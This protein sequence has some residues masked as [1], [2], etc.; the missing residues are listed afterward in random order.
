MSTI[1]AP[2]GKG[3]LTLVTTALRAGLAAVLHQRWVRFA[4]RRGGRLIVSLWVVVTAAFAMVHLIPGD[5]V[6]ASMGLNVAP[7]VVEA[8]REA[9]GLNRPLWQQY[10]GFFQ[11]LF[12]GDLGQ[13]IMS[14]LP[15]WQTIATR[16][17]ATLSLAGPA[18]LL[19]LIVAI[20]LGVGMAVLTRGGRARPAELGFVAS[21]TVLGAI[22]DFLYGCIFI[23]AFGVGLH[24]LPV[25][26]RG[27]PASYIMPVVALA[28]G[29]TA[30][31]ARIVRVEVLAVL[32]T[33]YIRTARAKRLSPARVYL[34]HGLPNA[35][36]ASLTLS[37]MLLAGMTIGTVF[38]ENV[39]AWPGLGQ[40]IVTAITTKDFPL[41]QGII[42][43]Y[44]LAVI[45]INTVVDVI[46]A[47]LDP[48][49]T[50]SEA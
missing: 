14:R 1:A 22:P 36:T 13:S 8:R 37:G 18:F 17:P 29:P 19:A 43:V 47:L 42:L 7:A 34:R 31:L 27:G 4:L 40:T 35:V 12:H 32:Q 23:A 10:L 39:F 45:V 38:I 30:V 2:A 46:L 25:A 26:G 11:G 3:R 15:V 33:D 50:V 21:S 44:G 41:A 20:P 5:P 49:S 16:L 6:R 24:W 28:V 9:L 48:R